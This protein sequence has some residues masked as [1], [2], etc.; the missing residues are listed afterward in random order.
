[1]ACHAV[2]MENVD[3]QHG[4]LKTPS[5]DENAMTHL[6]AKAQEWVAVP[7][8]LSRGLREWIENWTDCS[9]QNFTTAIRSAGHQY[10]IK[11]TRISPND[12][13]RHHKERARSIWVCLFKGY[14][15]RFT[16][17][18]TEDQTTRPAEGA[19]F[20]AQLY[21]D[22]LRFLTRE[23]RCDL[24]DMLLRDVQC[25]E[26]VL[27]CSE[28]TEEQRTGA[29]YHRCCFEELL[30]VV[31]SETRQVVGVWLTIPTVLVDVHSRGVPIETLRDCQGWGQGLVADVLDWF[32]GLSGQKLFASE[33]ENAT[34]GDF[35]ASQNR[36]DEIRR[37]FATYGV[38]LLDCDRVGSDIRGSDR[39]P[40]PGHLEVIRLLAGDLGL[41]VEIG[42]RHELELNN[43]TLNHPRASESLRR[44]ARF[45]GHALR[46]LLELR[47]NDHHDQI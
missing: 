42:V 17:D 9:H 20:T 15:I 28:L 16:V 13:R 3:L 7:T 45:R 18:D 33:L 34:R 29:L 25:V 36:A 39:F 31:Q 10:S 41:D 30:D 12:P 6:R 47:G 8:M 32:Q 46:A 40:T 1:M 14:N 5:S 2:T 24:Y 11:G 35:Q 44:R 21:L 23:V 22:M 43:I 19:R 37:V 38:S 4:D 27:K 26:D